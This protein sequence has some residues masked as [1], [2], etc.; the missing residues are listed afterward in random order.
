M[1]EKPGPFSNIALRISTKF[2]PNKNL[3]MGAASAAFL[4]MT[5]KENLVKA[6][7]DKERQ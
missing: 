1:D 7:L 3:P 2:W 5:F 6:L 4:L